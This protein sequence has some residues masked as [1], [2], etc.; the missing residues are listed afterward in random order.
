MTI[1]KA[2][3]IAGLIGATTL[4]TG[5]GEDKYTDEVVNSTIGTG[6]VVNSTIGT[7]EVVNSTIGTG[8]AQIMKAYKLINSRYILNIT[9]LASSHNKNRVCIILNEGEAVQCFNN[10]SSNDG[11]PHILKEYKLTNFSTLVEFTPS[12]DADILCTALGNFE[13]LKHQKVSLD[14]NR[15]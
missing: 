2:F 5:C 15:I 9:E 11:L 4:I 8:E 13:S 14:C 12:F 1:T 3:A 10:V 6:K 7:G